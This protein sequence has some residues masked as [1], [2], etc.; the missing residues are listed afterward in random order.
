MQMLGL[1]LIPRSTVRVTDKP[2]A[3]NSYS[4]VRSFDVKKFRLAILADVDELIIPFD[5][6]RWSHQQ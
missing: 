3:Y 1:S 4:T 5:R 2:V 6:F